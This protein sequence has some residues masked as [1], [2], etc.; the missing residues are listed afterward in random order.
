MKP[1]FQAVEDAARVQRRLEREQAAKEQ[2]KAERAAQLEREEEL[3]K[4]LE[5]NINSCV[6]LPRKG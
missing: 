2:R 1:Y 3:K 6:P 4:S 5:N